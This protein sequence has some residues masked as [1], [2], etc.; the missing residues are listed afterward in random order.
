VANDAFVGQQ[1]RDVARCESRNLLHVE[2]CKRA[3]EV[4]ALPE[5]RQ[6]A[7]AGLEAF[8]ADFLEQATI[9]PDRLS[10]LTIVILDVERICPAPPTANDCL[11]FHN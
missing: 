9:V 7:Q 10:P 6:P 11:G 5:Y 8:Q 3:A 1:P 2:V 4:L